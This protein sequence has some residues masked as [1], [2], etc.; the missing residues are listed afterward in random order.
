VGHHRLG[1]VRACRIRQEGCQDQDQKGTSYHGRLASV[2]YNAGMFRDPRA[3]YHAPR[4]AP[5]AG[6]RRL[7]R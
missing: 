7:A 1:E 4:A 6:W 5:A 3:D 2:C